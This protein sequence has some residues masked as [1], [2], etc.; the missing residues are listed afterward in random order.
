MCLFLHY[1]YWEQVYLT[2][3]ANCNRKPFIIAD[4]N[5]ISHRGG[6]ILS[7]LR[8]LEGGIL[9]G[10]ILSVSLNNLDIMQI[11]GHCVTPTD[12]RHRTGL[13]LLKHSDT[14]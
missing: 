3:Q 2:K 6:G 10:G 12:D 11:S 8:P 7:Y 5:A 14:L 4:T 13:M 1:I 9:Y